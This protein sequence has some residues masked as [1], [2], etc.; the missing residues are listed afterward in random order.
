MDHGDDDNELVGD[1]D[2]FWRERLL[3][4]GQRWELTSNYCGVGFDMAGAALAP[5]TSELK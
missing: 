5:A 4:I 3:P 2:E 1:S